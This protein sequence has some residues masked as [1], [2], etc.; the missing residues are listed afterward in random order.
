MIL[1]IALSFIGLGF[2]LQ[3]DDNT[4]TANLHI[5]VY[6]PLVINRNGTHAD[7]YVENADYRVLCA[8]AYPLDTEFTLTITNMKTLAKKEY[9]ISDVYN[10]KDIGVFDSG[11]YKLELYENTQL[12]QTDYIVLSS[13][14][15][16]DDGKWDYSIYI[17]DGFYNTAVPNQIILDEDTCKLIDIWA[18]TIHTDQ[19]YVVCQFFD[20]NIIDGTGRLE[21]EFYFL[22]DRY[23]FNNAVA[24]NKMDE[25]IMDIG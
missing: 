17:M 13:K 7:K 23:Y 4:I 14:N 9:V 1:L 25:I 2:Y 11:T 21:G 19:A 22:P 20:T 10:G 15:L 6:Q 16:E 18:F 24:S 12:L 8:T 3:T 5:S